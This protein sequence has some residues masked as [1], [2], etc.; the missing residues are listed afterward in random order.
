VAATA[1]PDCGK[2]SNAPGSNTR[3]W[4]PLWHI[5]VSTTQYVWAR[6]FF[7]GWGAERGIDVWMDDVGL[8]RTSERDVA[9]GQET[10]ARGEEVNS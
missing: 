6:D 8:W 1:P 5:V 9:A 7:F 3:R 2:Q 4:A 10:E